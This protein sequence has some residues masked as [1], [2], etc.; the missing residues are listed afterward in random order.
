MPWR[1]VLW[2]ATP[3]WPT[4]P[5][6][7]QCPTVSSVIGVLCK[8]SSQ[9]LRYFHIKKWINI[10]N[11]EEKVSHENFHN[12]R[13]TEQI[14]KYVQSWSRLWLHNTGRWPLAIQDWTDIISW[15]SPSSRLPVIEKV[16]PRLGDSYR[17]AGIA[18]L[19]SSIGSWLLVVGIVWRDAWAGTQK[20]LTFLESEKKFT[21]SNKRVPR[22]GKIFLLFMLKSRFFTTVHVSKKINRLQTSTKKLNKTRRRTNR[23][24]VIIYKWSVITFD[25]AIHYLSRKTRDAGSGSSGRRPRRQNRRFVRWHSIL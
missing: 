18:V 3:F 4:T 9:T 8:R 7:A 20:R 12:I 1:P 6:P 19:A 10:S 17:G 22:A 25:P 24:P 15:A 16:E 5:A 11:S 23:I 13:V 14:A 2:K 21:S